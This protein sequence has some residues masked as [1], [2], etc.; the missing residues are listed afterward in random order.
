MRSSLE[1]DVGFE[2]WGSSSF[3]T[4]QPNSAPSLPTWALTVNGHFKIGPRCRRI[5]FFV[6]SQE[7]LA[8]RHR[9]H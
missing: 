9:P 3:E 4:Y 1:F 5:A 8:Q 6:L 7:C 2:H